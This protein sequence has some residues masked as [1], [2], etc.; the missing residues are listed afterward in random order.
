MISII[1]V[2][3]YRSYSFQTSFQ[4]HKAAAVAHFID[5]CQVVNTYY[6]GEVLHADINYDRENS[7]QVISRIIPKSGL[8]MDPC[9]SLPDCDVTDIS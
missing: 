4:S 5:E 8:N 1:T 7:Y 6:I 3:I 9:H 2:I